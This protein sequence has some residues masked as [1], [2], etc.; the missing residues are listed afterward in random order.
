[1]EVIPLLYEWLPTRLERAVKKHLGFP[2]IQEVMW[3]YDGFTHKD[4]ETG[5]VDLT[6]ERCEQT[7]WIVFRR[8]MGILCPQPM[9]YAQLCDIPNLSREALQALYEEIQALMKEEV[10]LRNTRCTSLSMVRVFQMLINQLVRAGV[11]V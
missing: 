1:M 10:D 5:G 7:Q 2:P 6:L 4:P 8:E 3:L 11:N 9:V